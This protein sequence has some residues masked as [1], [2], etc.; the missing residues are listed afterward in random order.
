MTEIDK[1][2]E[3]QFSSEL[4]SWNKIVLA[5]FTNNQ[6]TS[7]DNT[8]VSMC[9]CTVEI[10]NKFSSNVAFLLIGLGLGL[11]LGWVRVG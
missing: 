6:L 10:G 9:Y 7:I 5:A 11:G 3:Q 4:P 1:E 2:G 8:I